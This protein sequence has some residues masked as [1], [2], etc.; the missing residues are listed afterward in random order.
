MAVADHSAVAEIRDKNRRARKL[1]FIRFNV[2][3]FP[4]VSIDFIVQ[5]P[6]FNVVQKLVFL[7]KRPDFARKRPVFARQCKTPPF[8]KNRGYLAQ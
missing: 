7:C 8:Q 5:Q 4:A 6:D 2:D 1:R 3:V